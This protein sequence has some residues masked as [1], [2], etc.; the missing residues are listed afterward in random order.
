MIKNCLIPF[1]IAI[2]ILASCAHPMNP[3][4][5]PKDIKAP[6]MRRVSVSKNN[7]DKITEV[8][9]DFN[10]NINLLNAEDNIVINPEPSEKP[11]ISSSRKTLSL[12]FTP[13]LSSQT[14]YSII[15]NQG[16]ADLNENNIGNYAPVQIKNNLL[17]TDTGIIEGTIKYILK[18]NNS[19]KM[20]LWVVATHKTTQLNYL[21][22]L[23]NDSFKFYYLPEGAYVVKI[24]D[25]Q[26]KNRKAGDNELLAVNQNVT[27]NQN[28]DNFLIYFKSK[29]K[30]TVNNFNNITQLDGLPG[31]L[32]QQEK[33]HTP[34]AFIFLDTL[35]YNNPKTE[36][37]TLHFNSTLYTLQ[38]NNLKNNKTFNSSINKVFNLDSLPLFHVM[39]NN[40]KQDIKNIMIK[41]KNDSNKLYNYEIVEKTDLNENTLYS[42]KLLHVPLSSF[43]IE[44]K[45]QTD[46]AKKYQLKNTFSPEKK[47]VAIIPAMNN[48]NYKVLIADNNN[49]PVTLVKPNISQETKLFLAEGKYK[50]IVFED[51]NNNNIIDSPTPY[52]N[53]IPENIILIKESFQ[54]LKNFENALVIK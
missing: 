37:D 21:T 46:T 45:S 19:D 22:T 12:K 17:N 15:L 40:T 30:L 48:V 1:S 43:V 7:D 14:N 44:L 36:V 31:Y 38:R 52:N 3:T 34:D 13:P 29:Q 41:D 24:F 5:G 49:K 53:Y 28:L 32:Q 50:I 35:Y 2:L 47:G 9:I 20:K 25:D 6:E 18:D 33:K 11:A 23:K 42:I 16:L 10:E 54:I 26:D 4:G 27:S 8:E 39:I 51:L